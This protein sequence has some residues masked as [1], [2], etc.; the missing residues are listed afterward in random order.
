MRFLLD[1]D[2]YAVTA[3]FL[4]GLGHDVVRASQVWLAQRTT[5]YSRSLNSRDVC[6]SPATETSGTWCS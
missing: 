2:V 5:S 1:Q 4:E 3:R 6:S